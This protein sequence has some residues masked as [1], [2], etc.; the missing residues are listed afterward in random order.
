MIGIGE[1]CFFSE[2][3]NTLE[4]RA[5]SGR[6]GE[7]AL[8]IPHIRVWPWILGGTGS[9]APSISLALWQFV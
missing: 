5:Y 1:R 7:F 2:G 3:L 6:G 9:E 4:D 8:G